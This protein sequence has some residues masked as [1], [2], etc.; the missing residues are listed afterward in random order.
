M[1]AQR[2]LMP[3]HRA[4][5]SSG[6][7]AP[8]AR[9]VPCRRRATASAAASEGGGEDDAELAAMLASWRAMDAQE[10]NLE[11]EDLDAVLGDADELRARLC[12]R[13]AFGT[14]GLRGL[15]GA[16]FSRMNA[17]VVA[18]TTQGLATYA[19]E[20]YGAKKAQDRGVV[21][22]FD[23][24]ENSDHF[25][26]VAAGVF[27]S[28]VRNAT[29]RSAVQRALSVP[30]RVWTATQG[31]MPSVER[32]LAQGWGQP[33]CTDMF[34]SPLFRARAAGVERRA[35]ERPVPDAAAGVSRLAA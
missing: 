2:L 34:A 19:E 28:R 4:A 25:A 23:A 30:Q 1:A 13:L 14:A 35:D 33:L 15:A 16:G 5:R 11:A 32:A 9:G 24:R 3:S 31:A 7:G 6:G 8:A 12:S 20:A 10:G 21:I 18:Q 22:G 26:K 17:V 27:A 29:K